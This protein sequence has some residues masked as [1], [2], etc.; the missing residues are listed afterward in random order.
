MWHRH[1]PRGTSTWHAAPGTRHYD[2]YSLLCRSVSVRRPHGMPREARSDS[3]RRQP[4]P[5]SQPHVHG[6]DRRR[7]LGQRSLSR[8]A[9]PNRAGRAV[10]DPARR[11]RGRVWPAFRHPASVGLGDRSEREDRRSAAQNRVGSG[12]ATVID[13]DCRCPTNNKEPG[14]KHYKRSRSS[15]FFITV[16][17]RYSRFT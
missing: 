3:R 10:S 8:D 2:T 17:Q 16:G 9:P 12:E 5:D 11:V 7:D 4:G 1:L 13:Q 14:T 15:T 6:V